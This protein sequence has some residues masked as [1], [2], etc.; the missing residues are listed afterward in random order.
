LQLTG[1]AKLQFD[2]NSE[3][4]FYR[5]GETERFWTFKTQRW[6]KTINHHKVT[7]EFI[8]F[9]PFNIVHKS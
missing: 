6:I 9:S 4:D 7:A 3:A 5:S 2:Q 8:D 1:L